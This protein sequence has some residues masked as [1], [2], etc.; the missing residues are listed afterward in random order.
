MPLNIPKKNAQHAGKLRLTLQYVQGQARPQLGKVEDFITD[1][2]AAGVAGL[3]LKGPSLPKKSPT[4]RKWGNIKKTCGKAVPRQCA[5]HVL[6]AG[7]SVHQGGEK[8]GG[9]EC[10]SLRIRSEESK[11]VMSKKHGREH[12]VSVTRL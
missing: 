9:V 11:A 10:N 4:N 6:D 7:G 8:P 12:E 5:K 3:L 2:V 1:A